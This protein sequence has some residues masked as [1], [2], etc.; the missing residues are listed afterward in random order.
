MG[1]DNNLSLLMRIIHYCTY[2]SLLV[3]MRVVFLL[4]KMKAKRR[5]NIRD[6]IASFYSSQCTLLCR[7]SLDTQP[8]NNVPNYS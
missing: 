1:R 2:H 7:K 8:E 3:A 6:E 4:P 5:K